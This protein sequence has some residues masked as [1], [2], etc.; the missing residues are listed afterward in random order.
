MLSLCANCPACT[1]AGSQGSQQL[2]S[3][4]TGSQSSQFSVPNSSGLLVP[5]HGSGSPHVVFGRSLSNTGEESSNEPTAPGEDSDVDEQDGG[6]DAEHTSVDGGGEMQQHAMEVDPT[7][8]REASTRGTESDSGHNILTSLKQLLGMG[9]PI[10]EVSL[11]KFM[12]P[13][14][15]NPPPAKHG[16][17]V[18]I[19]IAHVREFCIRKGSEQDRDNLKTV[20][21]SLRYDVTVVSDPDKEKFSRLFE[22]VKA[23]NFHDSD[24]FVCCFLSHGT[25]W[26]GR[27]VLL[28]ADGFRLSVDVLKQMAV[29]NKSLAGK[30]KLFF[31]QACRGNEQKEARKVQSDGPEHKMF[32]STKQ[33]FRP[34]YS[35]VFVGYPTTTGMKACREACDYDE[36][37]IKGRAGSWYITELCYVFLSLYKSHD[38]L[39]MVTIVHDILACDARYIQKINDAGDKQYRQAGQLESTL[40]RPFYFETNGAS[41][42]GAAT[43]S[44]QRTDTPMES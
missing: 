12:S 4:A 40:T 32:L 41:V 36:G 24:S 10:K 17:A 14:K 2:Q 38:L 37:N 20:L 11:D 26:N 42:R 6:V 27:E 29:D 9:K 31:I 5:A 25:I 19:N 34:Y 43:S 21:T 28:L 18:I 1:H 22:Q 7:G 39:S 15:M 30:P 13:Y 35:D 3:N 33:Q 44:S 8:D 23:S 16:Y